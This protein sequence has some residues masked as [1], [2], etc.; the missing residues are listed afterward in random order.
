MSVSAMPLT[1]TAMPWLAAGPSGALTTMA[2]VVADSSPDEE[3][4]VVTVQR[5]APVARSIRCS[6]PGLPDTPV[7]TAMSPPR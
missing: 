1:W 2:R 6:V 5:T 4:F 7:S 3:P